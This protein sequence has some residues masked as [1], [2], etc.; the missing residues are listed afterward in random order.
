MSTEVDDF[1]AHYGVKGMKWGVTRASNSVKSAV[2]KRREKK[3]AVQK[4][5]EQNRSAAA[6]SGYS[7]RQRQSD[8]DNLGR[9]GT[10]R[11]EKR[12][13]DGESVDKARTKEYAASTAK[14]LA[15]AAVIMATPTVIGSASRGLS[16]VATKINAKRGAEAAAKIFA[17][18]KGLTSYKTLSLAFDATTGKW[19]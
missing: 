14:G 18:D 12:I 3:A 5:R 2:G 19:K 4:E 11:V 13:A 17:D 9:R 8:L 16:G 10:R 7:S 15:A 1:L 6:K